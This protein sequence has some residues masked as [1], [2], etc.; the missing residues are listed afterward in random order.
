MW[1]VFKV[2]NK[3]ARTT[4]M[5]FLRCL[6]CLLWTYFT[7]CSSVSIVN[8]Q[9]IITWAIAR[10]AN[11]ELQAVTQYMPLQ[12]FSEKDVLKK[13]RK[14]T[15]KHLCWSL[16]LIKLQVFERLPELFRRFSI[17]NCFTQSLL[18]TLKYT[19]RKKYSKGILT[20]GIDENWRKEPWFDY[21]SSLITFLTLEFIWL[22]DLFK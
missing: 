20:K 14:F 10:S 6:Y 7:P 2:N 12:L 3:D 13:C 4:P 1:N 15:G 11:G 17:D 5:A 18:I 22:Q 21:F 9:H 8:F 19:W 16:F